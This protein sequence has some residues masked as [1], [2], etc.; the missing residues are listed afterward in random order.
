MPYLRLDIPNRYPLDLKRDLARSLSGNVRPYHADDAGS[1]DI[2][3]MSALP[4]KADF[5]QWLREVCFVPKA[6]KV[7]RSKKSPI[8]S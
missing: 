2:P 6:D 7:S 3:P 8:R 1:G 5:T 4:L